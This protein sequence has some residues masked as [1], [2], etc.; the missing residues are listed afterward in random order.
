MLENEQEAEK[1]KNKLDDIMNIY[2]WIKIF[3]VDEEIEKD[4]DFYSEIED[5]YEELS[6]LV[7][8][9]NR[10]RNYVT[11]KPY[12]QEKMKLNFGSPTLADGWSKSKEFSNNAI[13]M[14]KDGKYYIE[15]KKQTKQ[16][17]D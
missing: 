10:V 2:H 1:I 15:H 9:Y 6:P 3:L 14:L 17:S 16:G 7:S 8:L 5:I 12:S 11:Q 4:M 13:I